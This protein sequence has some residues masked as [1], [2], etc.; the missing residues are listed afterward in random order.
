MPAVTG[1]T[2]LAD[3]KALAECLTALDAP[4]GSRPLAV[5]LASF[6]G[7]EAAIIVLPAREQGYEVWAVARTCSAADDGT[8]SY[9]VVKPQ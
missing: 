7:Q 5:D 6:Q 4:A 9:Q 3:P 8:I 2:S 1:N